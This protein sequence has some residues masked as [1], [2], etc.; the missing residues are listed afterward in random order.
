M[1]ERP[2]CEVCGET[3]DLHLHHKKK[4]RL[5]SVLWFDPNNILVACQPCHV[6]AEKYSNADLE[7]DIE[8]IRELR[9]FLGV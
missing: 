8:A 9:A 7:P 1:Q 2:S 3:E 4:A 6:E 5:Y